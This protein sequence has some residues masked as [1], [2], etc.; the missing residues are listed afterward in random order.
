MD[1]IPADVFGFGMLAIEIFTGKVPFAESSVPGAVDQILGGKRPA[2]PQNAEDIGLTAQ[3]WALLQR[4][5]ESDPTARPTMK[6]V[7]RMWGG[8]KR[9]WGEWLRGLR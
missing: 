4:C 7:V 8:P 3:R 2:L 1:S 9:F 5:W 6:E